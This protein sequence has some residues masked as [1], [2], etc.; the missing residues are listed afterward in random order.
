MMQRNNVF[1]S[2]IALTVEDARE[3]LAPKI[4]RLCSAHGPKRV[5]KAIGGAD[6]KTVSNARDVG[7]D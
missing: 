4:R 1:P 6:A 7:P 3:L 2:G 5:A